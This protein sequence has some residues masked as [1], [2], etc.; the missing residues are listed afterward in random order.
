MLC[1]ALAPDQRYSACTV[2]RTFSINLSLLRFLP[3]LLSQYDS[4]LQLS[5]RLW[6]DFLAV[7]DNHTIDFISQPAQAGGRQSAQ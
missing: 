6:P 1:A 7:I 4:A 2:I 5:T 3:H